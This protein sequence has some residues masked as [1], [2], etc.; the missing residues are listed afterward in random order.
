[1]TPLLYSLHKA[2]IRSFSLL[3]FSYA[4]DILCIVFILDASNSG[5]TLYEGLMSH[6]DSFILFFPESVYTEF[7]IALILIRFGYFMHCFHFWRFLIMENSDW[8]TNA[9]LWVLY[10]ILYTKRLHG[11]FHRFDSHTLWIFYALF[12]FLD[13]SNSGKTLSEGLMSHCD[14][15]TLFFTESVYMEFF[16]ALTLI[17]FGYFM[18]CFHFW[19]FL[20]PEKLCLKD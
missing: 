5:K 3:W 19:T 13:V 9:S 16:I 20:I 12:S 4:L 2:F 10:F 18:H 7:F 15:F 6:C 14:S 1:M 8:R 17:R 11:V